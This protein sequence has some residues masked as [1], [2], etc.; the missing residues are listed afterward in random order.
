MIVSSLLF[1]AL[2]TFRIGEKLRTNSMIIGFS[3]KESS[4]AE[5]PFPSVT[6]CPEI[7]APSFNYTDTIVKLEGGHT[8]DFNHQQLKTFYSFIEICKRTPSSMNFTNERFTIESLVDSLTK[9][10]PVLG[11]TITDCGWLGEKRNCSQILTRT[12]TKEGICY[13]FNGLDKTEIFRNNV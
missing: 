3:E 6:I 11:S 10:G 5:I 13:T 9:S 4:V 1:C 12:L 2:L 8:G 7:K